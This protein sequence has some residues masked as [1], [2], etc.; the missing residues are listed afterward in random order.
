MTDVLPYM[1]QHVLYTTCQAPLESSKV[2]TQTSE[3]VDVSER[4]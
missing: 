4:T 3:R 1:E 2:N